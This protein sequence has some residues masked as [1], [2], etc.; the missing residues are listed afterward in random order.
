M[1]VTSLPVSTLVF[2]SA[3]A[4]G[5]STTSAPA[6]PPAPSAPT[7]EV[8]EWGLVRSTLADRVMLSGPHAEPPALPVAK[9]VLYFHRAGEGELAIDVTVD[10]PHG[11]L[12]EVWPLVSDAAL[13]TS[14]TWSDV[15]VEEGTCAGTRYPTTYDATCMRRLD[16]C[17]AAELAHVETSDADCVRW[18]PLRGSVR[19]PWNHLFYRGEVTGT[20]D[21]ALRLE[22]LA[23]GTLR[24]T[25]TSTD[26]IPGRLVRIHRSAG[27]PDACAVADAPTPGASVVVPVAAQPLSTCAEALGSSIAAAGL[28]DDEVSA[29]R[30]AWDASMFGALVATA[31]PATATTTPVAASPYVPPPA[32]SS[33]L[34]YVLPTSAADGL[35]ELRFDPAPTAVHRAIVAWIDEA[36][37]PVPPAP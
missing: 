32:S 31:E 7:Y 24:V 9:P 26:R 3:C 36:A 15:H 10:I 30:R 5:A 8:H 21:V 25:S 29:F 33:S 18:A 37:P 6:V 23:D 17:E 22:P 28:T 12:A 1:R 16:G 11:T 35:A 4:C 27:V 13:G 2:L 20:P 19:E 14:V 34:V